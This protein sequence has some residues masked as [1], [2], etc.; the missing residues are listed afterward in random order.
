MT[1]ERRIMK[2]A[3]PA[4]IAVVVVGL[5]GGP[6]SAHAF[7]PLTALAVKVGTS[8]VVNGFSLL[9]GRAL[10]GP[11]EHF[12]MT[13]QIHG[14]IRAVHEDVLKNRALAVDLHERAAFHRSQIEALVIAV[15]EGV[16]EHG[17]RTSEMD[18]IEDILA[19]TE[20]LLDKAAIAREAERRGEEEELAFTLQTLREEV[21]RI[22]RQSNALDFLEHLRP[23]TILPRVGAIQ[24]GWIALKSMPHT[25]ITRADFVRRAGNW[26]ESQRHRTGET[27]PVKQTLGD[28]ITGMERHTQGFAQYLAELGR[29]CSPLWDDYLTVEA[30]RQHHEGGIE[31]SRVGVSQAHHEVVGRSGGEHAGGD[32]HY[33]DSPLVQLT[34]LVWSKEV[35]N[36]DRPVRVP[37]RDGDTGGSLRRSLRRIHNDA[38]ECGR[39]SFGT[40]HESLERARSDLAD[41]VPDVPGK[42]AGTAAGQI[43]AIVYDRGPLTLEELVRRGPCGEQKKCREHWEYLHMRFEAAKTL[44]LGLYAF[45]SEVNRT[46]EWLA[47]ETAQADCRYWRDEPRVCVFG[48]ETG[49]A[50][51]QVDADEASTG[52]DEASNGVT[53]PRPAIDAYQIARNWSAQLN[54]EQV[55]ALRHERARA[56]QAR[57]AAIGR[58]R[59]ELDAQI[60]GIRRAQARDGQHLREVAAEA[61]RMAWIRFAVSL[62]QDQV[63]QL[64]EDTAR[65]AISAALGADGP[66][67]DSDK[68]WTAVV[69][70][71]PPDPAREGAGDASGAG[72]D[73]GSGAVAASD[74]GRT[75][76]IAFAPRVNEGAP[77]TPAIT[78]DYKQ[79]VYGPKSGLSKTQRL[80]LWLPEVDPK[81]ADFLAGVGDGMTLGITRRVREWVGLS[82]EI[83]TASGQYSNG[84]LIGVL[85]PGA[86]GV[87]GITGAAKVVKQLLATGKSSKKVGSYS[88]LMK[89]GH[90]RRTQGLSI[91]RHSAKEQSG[92]ILSFDVV[93][94]FKGPG[95]LA[96]KLP[97][98]HIGRYKAHL[99]WEPAWLVPA[100]IT[101]YTPKAH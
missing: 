20:N 15:G 19:T 47:A 91:I 13:K 95:S 82:A 29:P 12:E 9:L 72:N 5:M 69:L 63:E 50:E 68:Q 8:I 96:G 89:V 25:D 39:S 86:A 57:A 4:L 45:R 78:T 71:A 31:V 59:G 74:S 65:E 52:A 28:L 32:G 93:T 46:L 34:R 79:S 14:Q 18:R 3:R 17:E 16:K 1:E 49:R 97:H 54:D 92:R 73:T 27:A 60:A 75:A 33:T 70:E 55:G 66:D 36:L 87:K 76:L 38:F 21:S 10:Q 7:D 62:V 85:G 100:A 24:A 43:P 51:L 35:V 88:V 44:L 37:A 53:E 6:L 22:E 67:S 64:V 94:K 90:G 83:D 61:T 58:M 77:S 84:T 2:R 30:Y 99:P 40:E 41:K 23:V 101:A 81:V 80:A 26:L 48:D 56:A 98:M 11:D 42:R